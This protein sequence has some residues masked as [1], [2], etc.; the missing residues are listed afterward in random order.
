[1]DS[2]NSINTLTGA[3]EPTKKKPSQAGD[4]GAFQAAMGEAAGKEGKDTELIEGKQVAAKEAEEKAETKKKAAK[5][6]D[7]RLAMNKKGAKGPKAKGADPRV[8]GYQ[9]KVGTQNPATLSMLEKQ[10]FRLGEFSTDRQPLGNLAQMLA[11]EGLDLKSFS[12]QQLKSLMSR[13]DSKEL[14]KMM[15]GMNKEGDPSKMDEGSLKNLKEQANADTQKQA[16]EQPGFDL[17]ALTGAGL[18]K[19][20]G[21]SARADQRRKVLDQILSHIQVRNVANQTEMQL[22]LN[23]EYLGEVKIQLVHDENG[24]I[25]AKF[26]TTS[27]TT[28]EIL[29]EN[30]EELLEQA[31]DKGLKLGKMDVALVD[32]IA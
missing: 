12:P 32:E 27:K 25:S 17:Q 23:P 19:E 26:E 22:R 31:R 1:M 29:T 14:G 30:K 13:M 4:S 5:A 16:K 6:E 3:A 28:R 18:S 8:A 15:S 10:A 2:S 7:A 9:N 24:E 20:A 21:E 11:S